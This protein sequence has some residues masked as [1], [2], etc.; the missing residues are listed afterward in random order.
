MD[1]GLTL[2]P[3]KVGGGGEKYEKE[4]TRLERKDEKEETR[5]ETKNKK[6]RTRQ[7][8]KERIDKKEE[9]E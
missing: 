5:L 6:R 1:Y 7:E 8:T 2:R 9:K 4:Q 3:T